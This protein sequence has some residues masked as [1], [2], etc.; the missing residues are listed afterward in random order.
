VPAVV[1]AADVGRPGDHMRQPGADL[2]VTSGA[3]VRLRGGATGDR[4][5]QPFAL[6]PGLHGLDPATGLVVTQ[7]PGGIRATVVT[8]GTHPSRVLTL[9]RL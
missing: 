8:A 9:E 3:P 4:T 6:A 5:H 1:G 7:A 2:L